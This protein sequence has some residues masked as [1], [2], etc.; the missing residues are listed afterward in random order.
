MNEQTLALMKPDAVLINTGR[1]RLVEADSVLTA[2]DT[3]GCI[4]A[5]TGWTWQ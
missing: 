5:G 2:L 1:S 4:G 3:G